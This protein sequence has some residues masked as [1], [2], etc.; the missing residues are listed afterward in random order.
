MGT[1]AARR[2]S[3]GTCRAAGCEGSGWSWP[4]RTIRPPTGAAMADQ[5]HRAGTAGPR[6]AYVREDWGVTLMPILPLLLTEA[7][8]RVLE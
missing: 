5:C 6:N 3:D 8:E 2:S 4:S 7:A 1:V